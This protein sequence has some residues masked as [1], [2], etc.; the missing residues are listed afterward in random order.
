MGLDVDTITFDSIVEISK[1]LDMLLRG[2]VCQKLTVRF[3]KKVLVQ[4]L[5]VS[6]YKSIQNDRI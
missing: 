3:K 4:K 5:W 1:V 2:D 6:V